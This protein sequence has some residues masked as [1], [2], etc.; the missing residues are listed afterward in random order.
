MSQDEWERARRGDVCPNC[1]ASNWPDAEHCVSCGTRLPSIADRDS[2]TETVIDVSTGEPQLVVSDDQETA[3]WPGP[4]GSFPFGGAGGGVRGRTVVM[5]SG[6]RGCLLP[7]ILLGLLTC[8]S[9]WLI[10]RGFASVF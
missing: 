7:L 1:G 6:G 9:C 8:C 3:N 4:F 5:R 2:S 10:W